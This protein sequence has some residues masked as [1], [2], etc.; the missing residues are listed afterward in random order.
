MNGDDH[1]FRFVKNYSKI[2]LALIFIFT[3]IGCKSSNAT[4][5]AYNKSNLIV[6]YIDVGQAD[7]ILIQINNKN[8]LIDGGNKDDGDKIIK[9]LKGQGVTKLD[10]VIATHPHED[11]I[12]GMASII[13]KFD[14]GKFYAPKKL[15]ST[16]V[17]KNMV[18]ALKNKNLQIIEAKA[19]AS[20]NL[21][22]NVNC[23]ILAPNSSDYGDNLNNYSVVVK[24][25]YGDTKFLFTGDAQKQSEKEMLKKGY[26]LSSDVLKVGHHGS[27]S[28]SSKEFLDKVQPKIAIISC[29]K[30]N[31]YGHPH[32]ETIDELKKRKIKIYRTDKDGTI[33][34]E[35]DGKN[36]T[37]K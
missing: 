19:G 4:T 10:Y 35:S 13:K 3:L 36:I 23:E 1:L 12:G 33:V 22:K 7:S 30:D 8:L 6:H 15:N 14:L 29:G 9:Y 25:T 37:K 2:M 18:L 27:V 24:L 11:H 28:S 16:D 26:D 17:F 34:F 5:P 32:K 20:L 21:G 31:D